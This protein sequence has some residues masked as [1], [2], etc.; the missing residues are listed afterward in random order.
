VPSLWKSVSILIEKD[1]KPTSL[2]AYG[3]IKTALRHSGSHFRLRP[4]LSII[5][6]IF[7]VMRRLISKKPIL[8]QTPAPL[9]LYPN[10]FFWQTF[11]QKKRLND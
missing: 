7:S 5:P 6:P 11:F 10:G 1:G 2:H 3:K 8:F 4:S 9:F